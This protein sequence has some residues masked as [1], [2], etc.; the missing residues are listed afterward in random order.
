MRADVSDQLAPATTQ[1]A[2]LE[3]TQLALSEAPEIPV[4]RPVLASARRIKIYERPDDVPKPSTWTE[5]SLLDYICSFTNNFAAGKHHPASIDT[6]SK[7][8]MDPEPDLEAAI[9]RTACHE[10]LRYF[11]AANRVVDVRALFVRMELLRLPLSTETFNIMLRGA[12]K[13][14]DLHNF[15]FILHLMLKRGFLAN[16]Y[17]WIA[18]LMALDDFQ[19]KLHVAISMKKRGLLAHKSIVKGVCEQLIQAEVSVSIDAHQTQ[20]AFVAH[21]DARYG[22]EWLSLSG[23]NLV[24]DVLGSR[25][26]IARCWDFLHFMDSRFIWPNEY[27]INTILNHCKQT[28]NL[29]GAVKLMEN[30]HPS[31]GFQP[32]KETFRILFDLAWLTRSFNVAKVVWKYACTA[33]LIPQEAKHRVRTSLQDVWKIPHNPKSRWDYYAGSVI[34]GAHC[35]LHP[36]RSVDER[37]VIGRLDPG[38][39]EGM[40]ASMM[41]ISSMVSRHESGIGPFAPNHEPVYRPLQF[42][43]PDTKLLKRAMDDYSERIM[44]ELRYDLHLSE[45]MDRFTAKLSFT[46]MLTAAWN[47]DCKWREYGIYRHA[48]LRQLMAQAIQVP[49]EVDGTEEVVLL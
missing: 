4:L 20:E 6:L 28:V 39:R 19:I 11:V 45:H 23:G 29:L 42:E 49:L 18:L 41:D 3:T 36:L 30:V 40:L 38:E 48:R 25:G 5:Q 26:M 9:T 43:E 16:G 8:F 13:H 17:T 32:N 44:R 12:A 15:H 21:M 47:L 24:L 1:L 14:K 46:E 37:A 27:S 22:R 33:G 35:G 31:W 34:F 7:L 10:A 2:A